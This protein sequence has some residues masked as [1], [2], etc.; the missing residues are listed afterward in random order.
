MADRARPAEGPSLRDRLAAEPGLGDALRARARMLRGIRALLDG[1]G[2]LEVTTPSLVPA[3]DP[4][5]HLETFH[6]LLEGPGLPAREL[7]LVTSPEHCMKR[8]LAAGLERIYQ[9][10]PFFRNGE[11]S[12]LHN[13]EFTGLEWYRA[14]ASFEDTLQLTE[15]VVRA[16]AR[17]VCGTLRP[18]CRGGQTLDLAAPFR[19]LSVRDALAELAGVRAPADWDEAGLRRALV[20]A[21]IPPAADD[22][23][24]DLVNRALVARVE[25]A[26]ARL[27]PVFLV[28]YP[29]PMAALARLRP[30]QPHEAERFELF[31][32]GLEL[33]N[34]YGELT[35][36]AEQR[37][38]FEAERATRAR[39]GRRVP[40][41]DE[42]F[43][44]A[45]AQGMPEAGGNAVGL[46]RLL[47]LLLGA[48]RIQDVLP[49]PLSLELGI[50]LPED[51]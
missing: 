37:R 10:G 4:S 13:P 39:L 35:D 7:H 51:H 9:L 5:L 22:A 45:L 14:G 31:A 18:V 16:A 11:V 17:A 34:G 29:A 3:P 27:G 47:M 1:L 21:G 2:F 30:G 26:L 40:P 43:L 6:T 38:R 42:A 49:F 48:R 44:R 36:A 32:G 15:E 28:H 50:E 25:P 24:D 23:F 19:R 12:L 46:D 20:Q 33:C 8:M 41:L